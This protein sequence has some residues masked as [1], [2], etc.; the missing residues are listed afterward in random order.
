MFCLCA[1][2]SSSWGDN[3]GLGKEGVWGDDLRW[4]RALCMQL[5]LLS[6]PSVRR[7]K[8]DQIALCARASLRDYRWGHPNEICCF[9]ARGTYIIMLVLLF[10]CI[11]NHTS[12]PKA[13]VCLY[14]VTAF[15][16][17]DVCF[18]HGK[19]WIITKCNLRSTVLNEHSCDVF[20]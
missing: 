11:I 7:A 17:V 18:V 1:D 10:L 9:L 19:V 15:I 6:F 3:Q 12:M 4:C 8:W 20:S 16:K 14:E 13:L 5:C 2:F